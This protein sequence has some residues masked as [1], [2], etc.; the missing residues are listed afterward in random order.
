MCVYVCAHVC[1]Y[2]FMRQSI[3]PVTGWQLATISGKSMWCIWLPDPCRYITCS[4][5]GQATRGP[6]R[7]CNKRGRTL[8]HI[9]QRLLLEL[10][11]V[12]LVWPGVCRKAFGGKGRGGGLDHNDSTVYYRNAAYRIS[13]IIRFIKPSFSKADDACMLTWSNAQSVLERSRVTRLL[14]CAR[15]W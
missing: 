12:R 4:M 8:Q 11:S 10:Y 3:S 15:K 14:G 7:V 13:M 2:E 5:Q 6:D 1:M 9:E